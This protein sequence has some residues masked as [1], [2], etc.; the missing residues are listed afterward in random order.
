VKRKSKKGTLT[1]ERHACSVPF[2][3]FTIKPGGIIISISRR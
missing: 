1:G 3:Q 2:S